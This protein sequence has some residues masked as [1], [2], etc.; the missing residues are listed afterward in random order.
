MSKIKLFRVISNS[1]FKVV[2]DPKI[3]PIGVLSHDII[4]LF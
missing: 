3:C 2:L 1:F 4:G